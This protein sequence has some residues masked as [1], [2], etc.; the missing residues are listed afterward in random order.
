[1]RNGA[2]LH[3]VAIIVLAGSTC[4]CGGETREEGSGESRITLVNDSGHY[5]LVREARIDGASIFALFSTVP[6]PSAGMA[7]PDGINLST[8]PVPS[9]TF[10]ASWVYADACEE[11]DPAADCDVYQ[12]LPD[13]MYA[14]NY[15]EMID[16]AP[17]V[18]DGTEVFIP[19][20][21]YGITFVAED[22]F[23]FIENL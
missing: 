11:V 22:P 15:A 13:G 2:F 5:L 9:G 3:V 12:L 7:F 6:L 4:S 16:G 10:T 17:V 19:G 14:F 23:Y 18:H 8:P 20:G 1:M 21:N